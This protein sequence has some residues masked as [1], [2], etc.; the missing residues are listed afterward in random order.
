MGDTASYKIYLRENL[1]DFL[2]YD[3][4]SLAVYGNGVPFMKEQIRT[5]QRQNKS[6]RQLGAC[7]LLTLLLESKHGRR[8]II[9]NLF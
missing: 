6:R 7:L 5:R 9:Q 4:V 1:A 8:R 3:Q 2:P